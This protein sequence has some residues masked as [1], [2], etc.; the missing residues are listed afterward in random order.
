[1]VK[2]TIL[3]GGANLRLTPEIKAG[4]IL[5]TVSAFRQ[6]HAEEFDDQWFKIP[7]FVHKTVVAVQVEQ[8]PLPDLPGSPPY[9][10][11]W[12]NDANA[13]GA[14]CGQTCVAMLAAL[15]G[16]SVAVNDLRFQSSTSGLTTGYDLVNNF[17]SV[18][19]KANWKYWTDSDVR[20]YASL[21][22]APVNSICL[23]KYSGFKRES[24]QDDNYFGW[25]WVVFLGQTDTHVI[26][27]DPDYW[28]NR[29]DE[30]AFKM[31]TKE[32]W[33]KAFIPN[34]ANGRVIVTLL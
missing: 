19:I 10:S 4:N 23:V 2:I 11:Q 29:R 33:Y 30:G 22:E 6:F 8:P 14:D 9:K 3:P 15:K 32:E 17:D 21:G 25:H 7:L 13:R 27:H 1:M 31:Y 18:G 28:G 16:I 24:V 12:D 26:V 34:N 20:S 5:T